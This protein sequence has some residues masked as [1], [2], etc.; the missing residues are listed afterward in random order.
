[1]NFKLISNRLIMHTHYIETDPEYQH[2]HKI[3][4]TYTQTHTTHHVIPNTAVSYMLTWVQLLNFS[5]H[6]V[7]HILLCLLLLHLP[8]NVFIKLLWLKSYQPTVYYTRTLPTACELS[9][10]YSMLTFH[11][12][13]LRLKCFCSTETFVPLSTENI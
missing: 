6:K 12:Q 11:I 9:I 7:A 5:L 3:M 8:F 13:C 4:Q 1:M 2:T 10:P